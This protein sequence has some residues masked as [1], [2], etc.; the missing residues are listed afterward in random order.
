M[1]YRTAAAR[2]VLRA[3]SSPNA[4]MARSTVANTVFKAQLTS[5]ARSPAR[6]IASPTMALAA[7][8]PVTTAL[9]R[10]VSS[11]SGSGNVSE[12]I[13]AYGAGETLID[14]CRA[15]KRTLT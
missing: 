8:K 7:R 4:S 2:S 3:I 10:H 11:A 6:P 13:D 12:S 5:S 9:I 15:R 14:L 1:L